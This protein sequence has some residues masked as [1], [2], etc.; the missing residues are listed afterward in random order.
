MKN[1]HCRLVVL[2]PAVVL[3]A[4]GCSEGGG[5]GYSASKLPLDVAPAAAPAVEFPCIGAFIPEQGGDI[6][7]TVPAPRFGEARL[8]FRIGG[9]E[10]RKA[11]FLERM[12]GDGVSSA[13]V[14][15]TLQDPPL[16]GRRVADVSFYLKAQEG[17]TEIAGPLVI[18]NSIIPAIAGMRALAPWGVIDVVVEVD[19]D[20]DEPFR[21]EL[22]FSTGGGMP[23][24]ASARTPNPAQGDGFREIVIAWDSAFDVPAS[25]NG[26]VEV[27]L[28]AAVCGGRFDEALGVRELAL[29]ID[30]RELVPGEFYATADMQVPRFEHRAVTLDDGT[31]LV[32][33]GTDDRCLTS[34]D[35]C[36]VFDQARFETPEPPSFA[37]GWIDTDFEG[38]DIRLAGGGR[39]FHTL[40]ATPGGGVLVAGGIE[41]GQDGRLAARGELF[42]PRTRTVRAI[43]APMAYPRFHHTTAALPDGRI[44]LFGGRI[45]ATIPDP[46][47][48]LQS[49]RTYPTTNSIEVYD[50]SAP[51]A[52]GRGAFVPLVDARGLPVRLP[53]APGRALHATVRIAGADQVLGNTG[54]LYVHAGGLYTRSAELAPE[55]VLRRMSGGRTHLKTTLD[56]YDSG[57][58]VCFVGPGVFLE[59]PRAHG[60][61]AENLG[62]HDDRT[63]DGYLGP[64]NT[65]IV[66]GGS[67]DALPTV[68]QWL[69][70]GFAATYSGVGPGGGISFVR[71]DPLDWETV[72][73]VVVWTLHATLD[74]DLLA[75]VL[76]VL[77]T[78]FG[79]VEERRIGKYFAAEIAGGAADAPINRVHAPALRLVRRIAAADG[80]RT[81]GTVFTCGG[82]FF[83]AAGAQVENYDGVP[84]AAGELFNPCYNLIN[85]FFV[86]RR[87]PYDLGT[88]RDYWSEAANVPLPLPGNPGTHPHPSGLEGA[89]LLTDGNMAGGTFA[90]HQLIA[91]AA[92][93]DDERRVRT[94]PVGRAWHT[95][96]ALP[97][98]NGRLGDADDR[99]LIAGGGRG[100]ESWGGAP[101]TP[102][103]VIY[104]PRE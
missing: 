80:E 65:F 53:D 33:G 3:I 86:P 83:Y 13:F 58:Q 54:D 49:L 89:W 44:A 76:A 41:D 55:T 22:A 71:T 8:F 36:E 15:H 27:V 48:P 42:D 32:A 90:S 57:R 78:P 72:T 2:G 38:E 28:R 77:A 102:S 85:A 37:G 64:A 19:G 75:D 91:G 31:V 103:A 68:G 81:I 51:S 18:D 96:S 40:D 29:V 95:L 35:R 26:R 11:A 50:P 20:P 94:L 30:N 67:D 10:W 16:A 79:A 88:V 24:C 1:V 98:G 93:P 101:V 52:D 46:D 100:V 47:A 82:G 25:R 84:I 92:A 17:S 45:A 7:L 104:V 6:S 97:G 70:E 14:W 34:I 59:E 23:A 5:D 66:F 87:A 74:A 43:D 63:H 21:V 60:V 99:V 61:A 12:P 56:V 62:W 39:I 9:G 4:A 73:S 69:T